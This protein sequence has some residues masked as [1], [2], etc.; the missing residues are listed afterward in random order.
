LDKKTRDYILKHLDELTDKDGQVKALKETLADEVMEKR[1]WKEKAEKVKV[2]ERENALGMIDGVF[3]RIEEKY[4]LVPKE[5]L[6][7]YAAAL[8]TG[9]VLG[10]APFLGANPPSLT[11]KLAQREIKARESGK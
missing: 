8:A 9:Q 3:D 4:H 11:D 5:R 7:K 2:E 6:N 1:F 10:N